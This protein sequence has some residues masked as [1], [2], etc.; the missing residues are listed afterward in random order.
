MKLEINNFSKIKKADIQINGITVICGDNNTGKST[1]GKILFSI[2]DSKS[3]PV[4]YVSHN[5]RTNHFF[6][7]RTNKEHHNTIIFV[8]CFSRLEIKSTL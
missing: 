7:H 4:I 2:F 3:F 6:I 1:V 5:G 8:L